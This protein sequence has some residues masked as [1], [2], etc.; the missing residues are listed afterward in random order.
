MYKE[1]RRAA[2]EFVLSGNNERGCGKNLEPRGRG[3][4]KKKTLACVIG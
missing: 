1:R 2:K 3:T 4:Q